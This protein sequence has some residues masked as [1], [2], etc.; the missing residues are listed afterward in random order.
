ME[1]KRKHILIKE[2]RAWLLATVLVVA[3]LA[4]LAPRVWAHGGQEHLMGTVTEVGENTLSLKT[5]TGNT[6]EVTLGAETQYVRGDEPSQKKELKAGDRVVIH[7]LK[8]SGSLVA[9]EVKLGTGRPTEA[10]KQQA[11]KSV[12]NEKGDK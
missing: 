12:Q 1:T 2:T 8:K 4:T 9:Q 6:V 3:V 11:S 7:A 10:S 5:M